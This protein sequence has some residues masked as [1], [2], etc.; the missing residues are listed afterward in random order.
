MTT[1]ATVWDAIEDTP[2]KAAAMKRRADVMIAVT[3]KVQGWKLPQREAARRLGIT[4]PR[5]NELLKG[6]ISA[7]SLDALTALANRAGLLVD[8]AIREQTSR[9]GRGKVHEEV[10]YGSIDEGAHFIRRAKTQEIP[11]MAAARGP[12]KRRA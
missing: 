8:I 9:K 12:G 2:E 7:F 1:Y 5:L 4:Q 11:R 6:R 3:G 10:G